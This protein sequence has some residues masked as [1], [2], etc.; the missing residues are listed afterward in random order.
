MVLEMA[1]FGICELLSPRRFADRIRRIYPAFK[2]E[3]AAGCW[4]AWGILSFD[5]LQI[6][7]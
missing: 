3:C 1:D 7:L 5:K 4:L 6:M 2:I